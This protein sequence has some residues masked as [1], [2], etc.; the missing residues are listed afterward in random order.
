MVGERYSIVAFN[1]SMMPVVVTVDGPRSV[2]FVSILTRQ[3]QKNQSTTTLASLSH[4]SKDDHT[5]PASTTCCQPSSSSQCWT[6]GCNNHVATSTPF[7]SIQPPYLNGPHTATMWTNLRRVAARP[8][9]DGT[10]TP[11]RQHCDEEV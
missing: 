4:A 5:S 7:L 1:K 11:H 8:Q 3:P 9:R 6:G 10:A 2:N